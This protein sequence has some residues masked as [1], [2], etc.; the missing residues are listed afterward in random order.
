MRKF[1]ARFVVPFV[2]A[3]VAGLGGWLASEWIPPGQLTAAKD[4]YA[5]IDAYNSGRYR[6]AFW[7]F[8][9]YAKQG[10]PLAQR[11][12]AGMYAEGQY[13]DKSGQAAVAWWTRAAEQG[14]LR[15]INALGHYYH[16]DARPRDYVR[17]AH[18]FGRSA[19]SGSGYGMTMLG[20][21]YLKGHGVAR[22]VE[23]GRHWLER[24]IDE[25]QV[26]G[27]RLI[28]GEAYRD[29]DFGERDPELALHWCIEGAKL[30]SVY[31]MYCAIH[32]MVDDEDSPAL[33][34]ETAYLWAILTEQWAEGLGFERQD[35]RDYVL[36]GYRLLN[37]VTVVAAGPDNRPRYVLGERISET[38]RLDSAGQAR[39][40]LRADAILTCWPE[41][42]IGLDFSI[43]EC[44]QKHGA[45]AL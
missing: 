4:V 18:W 5:G 12:L 37:S 30:G 22:D 27:A 2:V 6:T 10:D 25:S 38:P 40:Q 19:D 16:Y 39:A 20:Y 31:A 44:L 45:P 1:S 11:L 26:A 7:T 29:G 13:V 15:S 28:L 21:S 24:A 33:D 41:P 42:P 14:N 35:H 3:I 34:Y 23:L 17:A 43:D 9:R 32:L 8:D 36:H